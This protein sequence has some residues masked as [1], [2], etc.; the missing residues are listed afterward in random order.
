MA[1]IDHVTEDQDDSEIL[2][3]VYADSRSRA[4][5]VAQILKVMSPRPDLLEK[6][7]DF[8][9]QLMHHS[10]GL[11]RAEREWVAVLTSQHNDCHY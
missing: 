3:R 2:S 8:Y 11:S 5:D 4:G 7:L 10:S 1:R 9:V 6:F